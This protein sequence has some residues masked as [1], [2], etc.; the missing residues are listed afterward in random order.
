VIAE[1]EQEKGDDPFA[2]MSKKEK[3]KKKKMVTVPIKVLEHLLIPGFFF[4][5]FYTL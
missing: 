5:L 2:N 3:K 4:L 1:Q